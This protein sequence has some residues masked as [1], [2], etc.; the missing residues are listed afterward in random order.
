MINYE[1]LSNVFCFQCGSGQKYHLLQ[2][3]ENVGDCGSE[4]EAPKEEEEA[5]VEEFEF[6][7]QE[8]DLL[9]QSSSKAKKEPSMRQGV[10][11]T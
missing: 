9:G 10:L 6:P 3:K 7:T 5:V 1:K 11:L 2:D 4:F 8:S